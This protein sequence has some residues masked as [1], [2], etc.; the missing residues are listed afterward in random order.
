VTTL[1]LVLFL[2]VIIGAITTWF[3]LRPRLCPRCNYYLSW[4]ETLRAENHKKPKDW[5]GV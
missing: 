3:L 2:G 1:L 5:E 4:R